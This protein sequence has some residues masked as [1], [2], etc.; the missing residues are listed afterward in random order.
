MSAHRFFL[1]SALPEAPDGAVTLPLAPEDVHHA[2][3]VLRVEHGEELE[4]VEPDGPVW[5]VRVNNAAPRGI[6]AEVLG[7]V[8]SAPAGPDVVLVQGVAKGEKMDAIVRHAV[9]VGASEI[10]PFLAT[11]SIVRLD[12]AKRAERGERWRRIAKSAA[13]QAHRSRVPLVRDPVS[14]GALWEILDGFDR[15]VVLWE[16]AG[17][18]GQGIADA[19]APVCDRF[20]A[21]VAVVVGPEGG[22][23]AEEVEAFADAGAV[24]A[25][26]GPNV[27]RA[28]TAALIALGLAVH[29]L[30]GLGNS[31]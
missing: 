10:V 31:R 30:G 20:G 26:L 25:T 15:V 21:R 7:R 4:V 16:E 13:E 28:E 29:E 24:T 1:A 8:E 18:E 3:S 5:L 11:R 9:E 12:P 19:L 27:L 17:A 23:S 2:V 14:T 22:L 6:V